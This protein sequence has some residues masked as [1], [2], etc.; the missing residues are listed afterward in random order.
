MIR[1]DESVKFYT[2]LSNLACFNL[3]LGLIQPY[4]KNIKYWDKEKNGKPY[5]KNDMSKKKPGRQRHLSEKEEYLLVL[6]RLRLGNTVSSS[7]EVLSSFVIY[8]QMK[9]NSSMTIKGLGTDKADLLEGNKMADE[10]KSLR[11]CWSWKSQG[12]ERKEKASLNFIA[13][14]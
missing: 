14:H 7:N 5:Y 1:D 11:L 2:G 3:N 12:K 13:I 8:A 4:T 10:G 9:H 6:C